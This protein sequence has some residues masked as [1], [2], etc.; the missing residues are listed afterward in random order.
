MKPRGFTLMELLMISGIIAL[1]GSLVLPS[2]GQAQRSARLIQC[3]SQLHQIGQ[4]L[5]GYAAANNNRLPPFAFS[6][7][8]ADIALSGHWGGVSQSGDPAAF[9]RLG[10]ECVNLWALAKENFADPQSLLCPGAEADLRRGTTSYFP[11]TRRF[12]TYCMRFPA[13]R[14]L[15]SESPWLARID[16]NLL[17][18]YLRQAGG[19]R[20]SGATGSEVVPQVR[21]DRSYRL[22]ASGAT[23]D[24]SADALLAD[25]FWR[26]EYRQTP[27][28]LQGGRSYD[29][30]WDL[31]HGAT[32]NVLLGNGAVRSAADNGTVDANSNSPQRT[33]APADSVRCSEAIWLFFDGK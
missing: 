27:E 7:F 28:L 33:I 25:T 14:T 11:Y 8:S 24:A 9:G 18:V 15:F 4:A 30:Q 31:C 6:D 5:H 3:R 13:S 23:Y 26:R 17:T 21:L 10:M 29:V 16:D 22:D 12:S 2:L 19:Q 1:L 32:Y 20:S